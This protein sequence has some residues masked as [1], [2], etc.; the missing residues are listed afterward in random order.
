MLFL[1]YAFAFGLVGLDSLQLNIHSVF[2]FYIFGY[3]VF[4]CSFASIVIVV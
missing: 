4:A 3:C 2:V 1:F